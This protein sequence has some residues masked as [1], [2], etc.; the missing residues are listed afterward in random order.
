[1]ISHADEF[2]P[3]KRTAQKLL[4]FAKIIQDLT[5]D[6]EDPE[7]SLKALFEEVLE[8]TGYIASLGSPANEEVQDRIANLQQLG[9]N[10][11]QYQQENGE[12]A[13]LQGFLEEVSLLTDIDN[14]NA[15]T[16]AVVMMTMHSAK[17]LEFPVVFLPGFEDGIFPSVQAIYNED[18]MEE[19]RRL[20]YVAIT[21]A[22]E[23]LY[24]LNAQHRTIFG[25][26]NRNRPSRFLEE[27]PEELME[28]SRAR[29]WKQ[30]EPGMN[31]P[32]SSREARAISMEAARNFGPS[33][34]DTVTEV[35]RPGD[36]VL[37]K[38][39]GAGTVLSVTPMGNDHLL[40]IAFD[41][42]GTKK[43]MENFAR[44]KR[45]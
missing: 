31:L 38:A 44:L 25:T 7:V 3:L 4:Q 33:H 42:K 11:A 9:S 14:Y 6:S 13:S 28:K 36:R 22:K 1:M 12:D 10:L 20:A 27:I 17:G 5:L 41:T 40:E 45:T 15:E 24:L 19:E 30:P 34:H 26:T 2:E 8:K 23:Q 18:Q 43:I 39:F 35:F 21:R 32:V 37:H 29:D 16:D